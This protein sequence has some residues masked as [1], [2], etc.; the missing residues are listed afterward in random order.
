MQLQNPLRTICPTLEADILL[1]LSEGFRCT[2]GALVREHGVEASVSG[3]RRCLERLEEGGVVESSRRGNRVEYALNTDHLMAGLVLSASA[4]KEQFVRFLADRIACW[5]TPPLQVVLFGS[6]A[7]GDMRPD[8]DIDLLVVVPDGASDEVLEA[9]G[10]LAVEAYRLTGNDVRPMV[11]E[12][13]EVEPAPI[14]DS[15]LRDGVHVFGNE[16]WL[17]HCLRTAAAAEA[18]YNES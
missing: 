12:A 13:S 6:A 7:R 1:A 14:F 9:V 18:T 5:S 2:P 3:V 10:D 4:A 8:S 17:S 16:Q 15:V 11:Y